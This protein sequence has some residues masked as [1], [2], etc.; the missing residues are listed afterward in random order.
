MK[1]KTV[2]AFFYLMLF[3]TSISFA[4]ELSIT[5]PARLY[6]SVKFTNVDEHAILFE[7]YNKTRNAEQKKERLNAFTLYLRENPD[8]RGYIMSYGGRRT[9][10]GEA[11]GRAEDAKNY[12][13]KVR[14]IANE[15]VSEGVEI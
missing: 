14:N 9:C 5:P 2:I 13:V 1:S 11:L 4:K 8:F 7:K 15:L 12:L 3:T 6:K 10:I